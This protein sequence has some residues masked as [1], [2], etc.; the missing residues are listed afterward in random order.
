[1]THSSQPKIFDEKMSDLEQAFNAETHYIPA[2]SR[3][4]GSNEVVPPQP[5]TT[6]NTGGVHHSMFGSD[7]LKQWKIACTVTSLLVTILGRCQ[8]RTK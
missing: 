5:T 4:G 6:T 7:R 1:M 3:S 8:V 2:T